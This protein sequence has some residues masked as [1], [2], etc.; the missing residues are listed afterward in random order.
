[1]KKFLVLTIILLLWISIFANEK[2]IDTIRVDI[3]THLKDKINLFEAKAGFDYYLKQIPWI[4]ITEIDED[5]SLWLVD[6]EGRLKDDNVIITITLE[7][8]TP[9]TLKTGKLIEKREIKVVYKENEQFT[10]G[11]ES[12]FKLCEN[13][14]QETNFLGYHLVQGLLS[15]ITDLRPKVKNDEYKLWLYKDKHIKNMI[16]DFLK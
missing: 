14:T 15:V 4:K 13:C 5:Y 16:P 2:A 11:P 9:S 12:E 6:Y 1:M 8:R 3:K 10:V 7:V